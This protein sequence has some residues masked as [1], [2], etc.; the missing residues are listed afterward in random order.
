MTEKKEDFLRIGGDSGFQDRSKSIFGCLDRLEPEQDTEKS[1]TESKPLGPR[2]PKRVPDHVLHPAKWT[3]YSLEEDGS[4]NHAGMT[5]DALNRHAAL[6]FMDEIR[7]R[8]E[9]PSKT[10][11]ESES[12][13]EMAEKHVFSKSAIKHKMEVDEVPAQS[14]VME[15][16]HVMPEYVIGQSPARTTKKQQQVPPADN[17][18]SDV[19]CLDH[20]EQQE[21]LD[22]ASEIKKQASNSVGEQKEGATFTK[23][24]VKSRGRLRERKSSADDD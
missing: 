7:K 15:G 8:N 12:D 3:K 22:S 23:R 21:T 5:G 17:T 18:P 10:A 1:E 14:Q 9:N 4:D 13:V 20:L 16:V 19:V 2:A 11:T 24:K 6:S